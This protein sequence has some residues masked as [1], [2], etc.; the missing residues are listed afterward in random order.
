MSYSMSGCSSFSC[1]FV[2]VAWVSCPLFVLISFFFYGLVFGFGQYKP[3][4]GRDVL[5]APIN[6][7]YE[8]HKISKN[9][10]DCAFYLFMDYCGHPNKTGRK[11]MYF[12][13]NSFSHG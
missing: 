4:R 9:K 12:Q 8:V 11:D 5:S 2:F 10:I 6:A 7:S 1:A 13:H 3:S